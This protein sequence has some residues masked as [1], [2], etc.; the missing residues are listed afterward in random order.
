MKKLIAI[1]MML[2]MMSMVNALTS[3]PLNV[4]NPWDVDDGLGFLKDGMLPYSAGALFFEGGYFP[5]MCI[6]KNTAVREYYVV[7]D[8]AYSIDYPCLKGCMSVMKGDA[9]FRILVGQCRWTGGT[10]DSTQGHPS[11]SNNNEN[12]ESNNLPTVVDGYLQSE[13]PVPWRN[14]II[15]VTCNGNEQDPITQDNGYFRAFFEAG[16]CPLGSVVQ[17]CYNSK[18]CYNKTLIRHTDKINLLSFGTWQILNH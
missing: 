4:Q 13:A 15:A 9:Q 2:V 8:Q 7:Q 1:T 12:H 11:N 14:Q 17:L 10:G 16:D 6:N 3:I 18:D 5:D